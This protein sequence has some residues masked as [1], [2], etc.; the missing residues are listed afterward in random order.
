MQRQLKASWQLIG[1]LIKRKSKGQQF[2]N[3]LRRN[4]CTYTDKKKSFA[5][6]FNEH[7]AN[8][9]PKLANSM[10]QFRNCKASW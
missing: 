3:R 8:I 4:N 7:L 2:P 1:N 5:N 9:G 6:Q 10:S